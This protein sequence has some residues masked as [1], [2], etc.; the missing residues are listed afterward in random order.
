MLR[1]PDARPRT[2]L[3]LSPARGHCVSVCK[4]CVV[5]KQIVNIPILTGTGTSSAKALGY[6]NGAPPP[7]PPDAWACGTFPL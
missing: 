7:S 6:S 3:F 2:A 1:Q 5:L 4:E